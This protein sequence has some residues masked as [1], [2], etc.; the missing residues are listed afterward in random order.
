MGHGQGGGPHGAPHTLG[1]QGF[2]NPGHAG[3]LGRPPKPQNSGYILVSRHAAIWQILFLAT[4]MFEVFFY[5]KLR[6]FCSDIAFNLSLSLSACRFSLLLR[7][8]HYFSCGIGSP[9]PATKAIY[10]APIISIE[11]VPSIDP[12]NPA[13]K[14]MSSAWFSSPALHFLFFSC[15]A[16]LL[17]ELDYIFC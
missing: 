16:V 5:Q 15:M 10:V 9:V 4:C 1:P 8:P 3:T 14:I 13:W 17:V 12:S 6:M 2:M 7:A 11:I